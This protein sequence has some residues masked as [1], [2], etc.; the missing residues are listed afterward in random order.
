MY[1]DGGGHG[2]V[3]A[4]VLA[5][6]GLQVP[7]LSESTQAALHL[8]LPDTASVGNPVDFAGGGERGLVSYADVGRLLLESGDVDSVLLTG[9]FGGYGVDTACAR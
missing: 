5:A 1:A 8:H 2:V 4:D 9:Y 3:A 6:A 7:P